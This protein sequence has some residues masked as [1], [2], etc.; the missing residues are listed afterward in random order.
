MHAF[1]FSAH[2]FD[3]DESVSCQHSN[4]KLIALVMQP[5]RNCALLLNHLAHDLP[6]SEI[7][8]FLVQINHGP[9]VDHSRLFHGF[10]QV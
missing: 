4:T 10:F 1:E 5:R 6:S 9:V 2:A 7:Q 3:L 8:E